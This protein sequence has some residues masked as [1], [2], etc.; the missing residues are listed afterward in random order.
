MNQTSQESNQDSN[1]VSLH[2]RISLELLSPIWRGIPSDYKSKYSY[3]I[4]D[5][6]E[7][8]IRSAAYTARLPVFLQHI[9]TRLGVSLKDK[10]IGCATAILNTGQD[11]EILKLLREETA[12]L[13]LLTRL[14]NESHKK[15]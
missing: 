15:R 13:V 3:T 1:L 14:E 5:Q 6:F 11:R 9:S 8:N 12:Y 7:N 10:D 4:W 2:E